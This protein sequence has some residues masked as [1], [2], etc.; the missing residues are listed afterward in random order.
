VAV[1]YFKSVL[2]GLGTVL[3]GCV[4]A[5]IALVIWA[6][7]MTRKSGIGAAAIGFSPIQIMHS[8]GFW[9]FIIVLFSAGFFLSVLF[10]KR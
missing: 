6:S 10:L 2:I 5:P 9:I 7:W 4:V 8:M 3:V 1:T